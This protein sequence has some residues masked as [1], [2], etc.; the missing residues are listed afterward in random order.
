MSVAVEQTR[1]RVPR[2]V[3]CSASANLDVRRLETLPRLRV[4]PLGGVAD[5]VVQP[6]LSGASLDAVLRRDRQV[7]PP[8]L[9]IEAVELRNLVDGRVV[10]PISAIS[11]CVT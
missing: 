4:D 5:S 2:S 3:S 11:A 1:R 6:D 8:D 9:R 7:G 10:V